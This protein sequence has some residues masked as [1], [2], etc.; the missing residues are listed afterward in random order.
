MEREEQVRHNLL[1]VFNKKSTAAAACRNI[2][3][4]YGEDAI[5]ERAHVDG[6][7]NLGKIEA[8]KFRLG[9]NG[10]HTLEKKILTKP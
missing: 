5:D 8:A 7:E 4:V 6:L 3:Q 1:S 10:H 9:V 2:C